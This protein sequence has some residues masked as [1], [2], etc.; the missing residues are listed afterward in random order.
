MY[1]NKIWMHGCY[2]H[3][4]Q[5]AG[6]IGSILSNCATF[7]QAKNQNSRQLHD[8]RGMM[9]NQG[10]NYS[11]WV[12]KMRFF[13]DFSRISQFQTLDFSWSNSKYVF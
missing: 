9:G 8:G 3:W 11:E 7:Y 12:S 2:S 6:L 13:D 1:I 10:K 4:Q 5:Q